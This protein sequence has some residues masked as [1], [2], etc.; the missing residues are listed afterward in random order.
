MWAA[1]TPFGSVEQAG[2]F[3][4]A[5]VC[6]GAFTLTFHFRVN[7]D[8]VEA[9]SCKLQYFLQVLKQFLMNV[10]TEEELWVHRVSVVFCVNHTV[11][12]H[13]IGRGGLTFL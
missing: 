4:R 5:P 9:R 10:C 11:E 6:G 13:T 8:R 3:F 12:F 7:S 1:L 2:R